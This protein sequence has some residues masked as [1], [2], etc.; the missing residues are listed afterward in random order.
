MS[1]LKYAIVF[2]G[3]CVLNSLFSAEVDAT[4]AKSR[5]QARLEKFP[6]VA[7]A[8]NMVEHDLVPQRGLENPAVIDAM[9][10]IPRS[11]F[12]RADQRALAY[13]DRALP[14]NH[15][16]TI[17]PPYIVAFMT[18]QL[19][20]KPGDR[21]LEI[22]TGSGYQAAVLSLLVDEVYSIEIVEPL[23]L[24][25]QKLLKTLGMDNVR[26]RVG[27]GFQGW[28]EAAPFDSIIVTCSPEAIPQPLIDQLREGGRL[29]IPLGERFQQTFF[30]CRKVNGQ[31]EREEL[32]QTL[33]VPMTGE[34]EER[35]EM[36][37]DPK[38]PS[39]QGGDF[40]QLRADGSPLGWHYAR[41]VTI[42]EETQGATPKRFARF[43]YTKDNGEKNNS[44]NNNGNNGSQQRFSQLLQGLMMDGREVSRLRI[45]YEMRGEK[46]TPRPMIDHPPTALLYLYD[47]NRNQIAEVP[48]GRRDGTFDW[49]KVSQEIFIPRHAREAVLLIGLAGAYGQLDVSDV[50]IAPVKK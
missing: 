1:T 35:R 26:V 15:G 46:I 27:D 14:I 48:I 50:R 16:Q 34:A 36:K 44:A 21:V 4:D 7:R 8:Q 47:A 37:P 30:L 10:R 20:P 24:Q 9:S 29:I 38:N 31:L 40:A 17:S 11:Q 12:V 45:T 6:I 23:G 32:S 22:G 3:F 5:R 39:L 19:D 18:E 25:A 33:F 28:P 43:V 41:S 49:Q 13:Q 2:F 42:K